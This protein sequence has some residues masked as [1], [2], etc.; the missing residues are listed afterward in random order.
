MSLSFLRSYRISDMAVFDWIASFVA[1]LM[2][3]RYFES[4]I[5]KAFVSVFP[6]SIISHAIFDIETVLMN[7]FHDNIMIK[8]LF[9]ISVAM[10]TM[11]PM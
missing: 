8:I 1:L 5:W 10:I 4:S 3:A 11:L 7:M 9:F 6:L 2:A